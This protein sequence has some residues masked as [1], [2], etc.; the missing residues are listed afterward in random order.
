MVTGFFQRSPVR[1]IRG[2][3]SLVELVVVSAA[4]VGLAALALPGIQAARESA[5]LTICRNHVAQLAKAV[6]HHESALQ[7]FPSGGWGPNWLPVDGRASDTAQPGGWTYGIL[8]YLDVAAVRD[9]IANLD[10]ATATPA[11]Q[12]FAAAPVAVFAC[13]SRRTAEPIGTPNA[14]AYRTAFSP[15]QMLPAV[16]LTDYAANGGSTAS[17]PPLALLER[18]LAFVDAATKVTF[19]HVPPGS[20]NPQT[21]SLAIVSTEQ[22]HGDHEGDH[23]GPCASCDDD[24]ATIAVDP[25]SLQ[26]GDAWRTMVPY[27]RVALPDGGI[28]DLQDGIVHRMSRITTAAVRD[29]LSKTYLVGEKYVAASR[30]RTG[31][32][33]G[34]NRALSAGYSS[35]NVRWAYDP[36][37]RDEPQASRPNTFGSPHAAGWNVALADG[38]VRTIDFDVDLQV[39]RGLAARADGRGA[40]P[41]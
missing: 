24:L 21:Q 8:P 10:A 35:S 20:T 14:A 11:Y 34:D 40:V 7:H 37:Q 16:A 29:G 23:I 32:D 41:E 26:Q 28:P 25:V 15:S 22:G 38:A 30:Y 2:A 19:C 5:R 13:P 4:V 3:F 1:R 33:P 36:P 6:L 9:M 27:A 17:C 12:Q 39:H 31:T 18:A